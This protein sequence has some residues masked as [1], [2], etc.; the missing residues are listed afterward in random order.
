M[1]D[2]RALFGGK[3]KLKLKKK[4]IEKKQGLY[5]IAYKH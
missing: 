5:E 2:M 4:Y 1:V 3:R